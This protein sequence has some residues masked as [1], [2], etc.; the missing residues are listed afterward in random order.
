MKRG[1]LDVFKNFRKSLTNPKREGKSHSAEKSGRGIF[2]LWR[3]FVFHVRG[4]G[5][6]IK[7]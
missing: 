7:Q 4:F 3:G 2:Q 5:F 1:P 6:K